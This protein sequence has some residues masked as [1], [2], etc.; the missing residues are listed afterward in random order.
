M[1]PKLHLPELAASQDQKHVT[2]NEALFLI[3][4]LIQLSVLSKSISVPP[5]SPTLGDA[6][7]VNTGGSADWLAKDGQIAIYD[8][9]GWL[10]QVP[11]SGWQAW[12]TDEALAYRLVSGIWV[13]SAVSVV[14]ANGAS[15]ALMAVEE[16]LIGLSGAAVSSTIVIPSRCVLQGVSVRTTADITGAA[17]FDCGPAGG[18]ANAYGGSLGIATGSTNIGVIGPTA[19]YSDTAVTLTAN[20]GSFTGGSAR[21]ALHY[22]AFTAPTS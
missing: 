1:T 3:D 18:S 12:V 16:E 6:Y 21:I 4:Q 11:S 15:S 7:I 17:S 9:N 5:G 8:G 10:F 2:H 22:L 14:T 20:G 19:F 13:P